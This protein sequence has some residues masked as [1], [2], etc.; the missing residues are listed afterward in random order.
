MAQMA[1]ARRALA[2]L[3]GLQFHKLLGSGGGSR[4]VSMRPDFSTWVILGVWTDVAAAGAFAFTPLAST[5]RAVAEEWWTIS[6]STLRARGRWSGIA[7]FGEP[8]EPPASSGRVA[9]LTRASIR[10]KL[11][12]RFW[13]RVPEVQAALDSAPGLLF[14]KGIGELPLVEQATFSVWE[15]IEHMR[16][17][18]YEG[19]AHRAVISATHELGWYSEELFARFAVLNSEGTWNGRDPLTIA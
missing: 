9:V 10:R 18:A 17:F 14:S 1:L 3:P 12:P 7:P 16:A 6:L 4:G 13:S 2:R 11:V 15:S 19:A 5:W 8:H